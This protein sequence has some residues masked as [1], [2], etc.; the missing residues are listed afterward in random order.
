LKTVP[1][2]ASFLDNAGYRIAR[3]LIVEFL[4]LSILA[5]MRDLPGASSE[6]HVAGQEQDD[7]N[8]QN[9]AGR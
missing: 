9:D 1:F 6:M 2:F 3:R 5:L 8:H 4:V 7:A